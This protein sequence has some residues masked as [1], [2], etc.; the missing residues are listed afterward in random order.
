MEAEGNEEVSLQCSGR[1]V[2]SEQKG[3]E[4]EA[5][6]EDG[7]V[8]WSKKAEVNEWMVQRNALHNHV[9]HWSTK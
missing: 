9:V 5:G 4:R 2:C 1:T 6:S 3:P 7:V 8:E